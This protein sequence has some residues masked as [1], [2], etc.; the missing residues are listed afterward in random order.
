MELQ[1]GFPIGFNASYK[2]HLVL[3]NQLNCYC[4]VSYWRFG[5]CIVQIFKNGVNQD[6][7]WKLLK[8]DV[9]R[10]PNYGNIL[11]AFVASGY[12]IICTITFTLLCT[13]IGFVSPVNRGSLIIY[14]GAGYIILG[15]PTGYAFAK[16]FKSFGPD[17]WRP[18]SLLISPFIFYMI[19]V[20]NE[21]I[22]SHSGALSCLNYELTLL[23]IVLSLCLMA[24]LMFCSAFCGFRWSNLEYPV[25]YNDNPR[26][27]PRHKG[28]TK[29]FI[30]ILLGGLLPFICICTQLHFIFNSLY[31]SMIYYFYG[32][33]II[34]FVL[35]VVM[36]SEVTILL[37]YMQ[38]C[39]EVRH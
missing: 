22:L 10:P 23:W 7:K 27:I 18:I 33:L 38:L 3:I 11:S 28:C 14:A 25:K 24:V 16:L 31:S 30:W 15:L 39:V 32:F 37:C 12:Q 29:P 36:C 2:H 1:M 19:F 13:L 21:I 6:A 35:M 17:K 4:P 8:N 9:F 26:P 5:C 20:I 34:D